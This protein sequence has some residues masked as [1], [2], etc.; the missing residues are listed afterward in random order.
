MKRITDLSNSQT[1]NRFATPKARKMIRE[2]AASFPKYEKTKKQLEEDRKKFRAHLIRIGVS[3]SEA[4]E[5]TSKKNFT[6]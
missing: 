5:M 1:R 2:W 3:R 6:W 4:K